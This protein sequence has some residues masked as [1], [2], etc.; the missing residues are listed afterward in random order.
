MLGLTEEAFEI[1]YSSECCGAQD[2]R[3]VISKA[4]LAVRDVCCQRVVEADCQ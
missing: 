4:I 1:L 3:G 2:S